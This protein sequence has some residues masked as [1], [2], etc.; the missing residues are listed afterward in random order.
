MTTEF[1]R[2]LGA[3]NRNDP[4]ELYRAGYQHGAVA[5]LRAVKALRG[6]HASD[7][8][9]TGWTDVQLQMWR[10]D[11]DAAPQPPKPPSS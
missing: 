7:D 8:A 2:P 9:F 10:H 4:E 6:K 3:E 5:A 11:R 1:K